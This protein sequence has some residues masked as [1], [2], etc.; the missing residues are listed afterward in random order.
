VDHATAQPARTVIIIGGRGQDGSYLGAT[1]AE[2]PGAGSPP[3][4]VIDIVRQNPAP[5]DALPPAPPPGQRRALALDIGQADT[6]RRLVESYEPHAIVH[7]AAVHGPSGAMPGVSAEPAM[8]RLHVLATQYLC[9][10]VRDLSP[11]TQLI[12]ASSSKVYE[13]LA[14]DP[15]GALGAPV[16]RSADP[17]DIAIDEGTPAHPVGAYAVTKAAGAALVRAYRESA[18]LLAHSIVLFNHESPRRPPGYLSHHIAAQLAAILRGEADHLTVRDASHR[19]DWSD[20]RD[21]MTAVALLVD[22]QVAGD[23]VLGSGRVTSVGALAREAGHLL[24][25][26]ELE[27]RSGSDPVEGRPG[28]PA[29]VAQP[30]RARALLG[31]SGSRPAAETLAEMARSLH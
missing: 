23:F 5:P 21:L 26:T 11:R 6:V 12:F 2:R 9:E 20:A 18:G 17:V 4:S 27:I 14:G 3:T 28:R 1:L 10:A 15:L 7:L 29:L 8:F 22:R 16:T 13:G 25:I 19:G 30:A 31:W 24:G